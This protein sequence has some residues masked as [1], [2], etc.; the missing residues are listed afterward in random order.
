VTNIRMQE[1]IVCGERIIIP[2]VRESGVTC[3]G[4]AFGGICPVALLVGECG[5]WF[6]V[7]IE[8]GFGPGEI[9][10]M[11]RTGD[12]ETSTSLPEE[13]KPG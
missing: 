10:E 1:P 13:T 7:A 6:F 3:S 4:G 5:K 9:E 12:E 2:V 8:E 11:Y